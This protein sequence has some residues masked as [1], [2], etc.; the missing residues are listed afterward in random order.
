MRNTSARH[1]GIGVAFL[2]L[3]S[4]CSSSTETST[5]STTQPPEEPV[6]TTSMPSESTP[7]IA[8]AST[9]PPAA[10]EVEIWA[11]DIAGQMIEFQFTVDDTGTITGLVN[12]PSEEAPDVPING[13]MADGAVTIKIPAVEAVFE[14]EVDGTTM[15]GT[16]YQSG[17]EVPAVFELRDSPAHP[18]STAGADAAVPVRGHRRSVRE[19]GHLP[20]RHPRRARR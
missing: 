16:W 10:T 13:V 11:G 2:L 20:R 18:G 17:A 15:S 19:W 14:G 6:V 12:S 3:L 4:S 5:T 9:P 8:P 7:S 1:I